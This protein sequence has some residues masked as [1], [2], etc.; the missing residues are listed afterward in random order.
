MGQFGGVSDYFG[1]MMGVLRALYF[2]E[3]NEL[4]VRNGAVVDHNLW[5]HDITVLIIDNLHFAG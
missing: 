4:E 5:L 1:N 3:V 2:P